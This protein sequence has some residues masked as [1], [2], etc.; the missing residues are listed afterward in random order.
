M[1]GADWV[2]TIALL[3]ALLPL[4]LFSLMIVDGLQERVAIRRD[5][6]LKREARPE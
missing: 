1:I 5:A 4:G 2:F 3:L 6:S